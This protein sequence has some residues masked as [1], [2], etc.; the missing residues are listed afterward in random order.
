MVLTKMVLT[1]AMIAGGVCMV[2]TAPTSSPVTVPMSG[3]AS[4]AADPR[5]VIVEFLKGLE[6]LPAQEHQGAACGRAF[7]TALSQYVSDEAVDAY[8]TRYGRGLANL[9]A[10]E[11]TSLRESLVAA[12]TSMIYFYQGKLMYDKP[13]KVTS[14]SMLG[15]KGPKPFRMTIP[16]S[17]PEYPG[18]VDVLVESVQ[19]NGVWKI[20]NVRLLPL[21][22]EKKSSVGSVK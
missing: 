1:A 17:G 18:P 8:S 9:S 14:I 3:P 6:A 19:E 12:W 21:G 22:R 7:K 5:Q 11:A 15:A 16:T 20:N 2:G 10:T 4:Q 13:G